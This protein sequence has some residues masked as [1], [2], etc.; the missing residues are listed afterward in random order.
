M[1]S[2]YELIMKVDENTAIGL[3][4]E[5]ISLENHRISIVLLLNSQKAPAC[6]QNIEIN[7]KKG[8]ESHSLPEFFF[9]FRYWKYNEIRIVIV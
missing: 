3:K 8:P 1:L 6:N 9:L 2:E 5:I 4:Q 7:S